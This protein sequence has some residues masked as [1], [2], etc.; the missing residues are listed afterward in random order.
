MLP[1]LLGNRSLIFLSVSYQ[2][3][4]FYLEKI[5]SEVF[6]PNYAE[7]LADGRKKIRED[8]KND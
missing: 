4:T 7:I 6:D 3:V 8:I 1:N 2:A 5:L